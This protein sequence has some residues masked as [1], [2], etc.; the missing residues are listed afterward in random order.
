MKEVKMSFAQ[1]LK[2]T[3][4]FKD[5]VLEKGKLTIKTEKEKAILLDAL[6]FMSQH[7]EDEMYPEPSD[8]QFFLSA[9]HL[10]PSF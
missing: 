1:A 3:E 7:I 9:M 2:I 10:C 6:G 8:H 4:T 5:E